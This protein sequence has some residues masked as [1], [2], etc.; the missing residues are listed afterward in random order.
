MRIPAR[1]MVAGGQAEKVIQGEF[2]R[3]QQR[4]CKL[5]AFGH[6]DTRV[7]YC[8]SGFVFI[9]SAGLGMLIYAL[10]NVLYR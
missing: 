4:K 6:E 9:G 7:V 10:D 2:G 3:D 1:N 8:G 5:Q